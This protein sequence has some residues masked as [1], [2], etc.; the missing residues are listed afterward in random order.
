M[1]CKNCSL[2]GSID[3]TRGSFEISGSDGFMDSVN[4]T[5]AFFEHGSVEIIA[6]GLFAQVELEFD[7]SASQNLVSFSAQLPAIPLVPF[8]VR[9]PSVQTPIAHH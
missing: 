3:L 6:N 1:S 4:N 5:I 9:F 2:E 7:L 8:E